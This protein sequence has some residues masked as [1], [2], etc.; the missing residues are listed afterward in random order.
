M[1]YEKQAAF[2]LKSVEEQVLA[3]PSPEARVMVYIAEQLQA[4]KYWH[5][6]VGDVRVPWRL[7]QYTS[8]GRV[9]HSLENAGSSFR[10]NTEVNNE[11]RYSSLYGE[12]FVAKCLP[13]P[14]GF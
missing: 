11:T 6:T 2:F 3:A 7:M 10:L 1:S 13:T 14:V 12:R 4:Q 8:V 9:N 5:G